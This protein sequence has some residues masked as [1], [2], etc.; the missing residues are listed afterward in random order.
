MKGELGE[1]LRRPDLAVLRRKDLLHFGRA[2]VRK[3]SR[4][5]VLCDR[6][7]DGCAEGEGEREGERGDKGEGE[8][9]PDGKAESRR[10]PAWGGACPWVP[11]RAT[12]GA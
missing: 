4:G 1:S 7:L 10:A 12:W 3:F 2:R 11:N 6:G 8:G 5:S 9:E